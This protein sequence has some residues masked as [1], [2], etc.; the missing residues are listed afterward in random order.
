MSIPRS[1]TSLTVITAEG[2]DRAAL[3]TAAGLVV[4]LVVLFIVSFVPL[5]V[6]IAVAVAVFLSQRKK[7][8]KK[9]SRAPLIRSIRAEKA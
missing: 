6:V 4:S 5:F 8:K 1:L 3:P 7:A 2:F 9:D